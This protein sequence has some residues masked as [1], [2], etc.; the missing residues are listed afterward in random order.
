MC[1]V[2]FAAAEIDCST[3]ISIDPTYVK[4]YARRASARLSLS[5]LQDAKKD[6]E[7]VLQLEPTNKGATAELNKVE[8]VS[9]SLWGVGGPG[10]DT[11]QPS[12]CFTKHKN[13][14]NGGFFDTKHWPA[15]THYL[16]MN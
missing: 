12:Q 8:K 11:W 14:G 13:M 4:A 1:C 3:A 9:I 7:R 16:G 2:R 5:K 10:E 6:F 15:L